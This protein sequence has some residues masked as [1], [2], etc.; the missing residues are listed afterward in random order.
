[1]ALERVA[2]HD[3]D[4]KPIGVLLEDDLRLGL[5]GRSRTHYDVRTLMRVEAPDASTPRA[6][7]TRALI[8]A[9]GLGSRLSPLTDSTPKPLLP[10]DGQPL[11]HR[12]LRQVADAG[13]R[14]CWLSILYLGEQIE[15]SVGDGSAFGLQ[16][17]YVRETDPLGTAGALGL[18]D[19]SSD[20]QSAL[21][22]MNGDVYHD[23][24]LR[25][26]IAWHTRHGN[27]ATVATQLHEVYVPFGLAH[28]DGQRLERLEEK[29]T[30]RLPVNAGIYVFDE[31]L[32]TEVP[33]GQVWDMV[34]W[35]NTL[36]SKGCVGQFPIVERWHDIGSLREYRKL[37]G[38]GEA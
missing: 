29:P 27:R 22:V 33:T 21:L 30:L 18:V 20:A 7:A 1:M 36:A 24:N 28:F 38:D 37:A 31:E 25:A 34:E 19:A 32:R 4:A 13:V 11:L 17:R 35:L 5:A 8:M 16:V 12:L 23:V 9:G 2:I 6:R 15:E 10:I 14:E 26:L 3:A